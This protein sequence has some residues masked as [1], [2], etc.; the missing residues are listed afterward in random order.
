MNKYEKMYQKHYVEKKNTV[1]VFD[2]QMKSHK[3]LLETNNRYNAYQQL[4]AIAKENTEKYNDK[5]LGIYEIIINVKEQKSFIDCGFHYFKDG[6]K[7]SYKSYVKSIMIND[8]ITKK[9]I[10]TIINKMLS[11]DISK[12]KKTNTIS[13]DELLNM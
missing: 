11:T 12:F 6:K 3:V 7:V 10:H 8:N 2:P 5:Y 13:L 9:V 1:V 4:L